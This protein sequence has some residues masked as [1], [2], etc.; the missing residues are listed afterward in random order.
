M[1]SL[2]KYLVGLRDSEQKDAK[3]NKRKLVER[4]RMRKRFRREEYKASMDKS[5]STSKASVDT[6]SVGL[7]DI[8]QV[9]DWSVRYEKDKVMIASV[10]DG[11][12]VYFNPCSGKVEDSNGRKYLVS[13][14]DVSICTNGSGGLKEVD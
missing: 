9:L 11:M 5:A 13:V 4:P 10:L 2:C 3:E 8:E 12:E 6:V 1:W 7:D 14:P